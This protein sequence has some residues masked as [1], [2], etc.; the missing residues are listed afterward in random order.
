MDDKTI[1]LVIVFNADGTEASR[2]VS[3]PT[4]NAAVAHVLHA[5]KASAE[6]VWEVT[7]KGGKVEEVA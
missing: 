4:R 2:L 1:F 3:A 5:C 7:A 6:D